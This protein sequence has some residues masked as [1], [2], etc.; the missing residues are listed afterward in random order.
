MSSNNS[1]RL[2]TWRSEQSAANAFIASVNSA[3]VDFSVEK[4]FNSSDDNDQS[5]RSYE[6]DPHQN[7]P[8]GAGNDQHPN[9]S[10]NS[11]SSGSF[12]VAEESDSSDTEINVQTF[13]EIVSSARHAL[14]EKQ[15]LA[16][17]DEIANWAS[18]HR[19]TRD[20][21]NGVLRILNE[22]FPLIP[23]DVRTLLQTE[24]NILIS[25]K[26]GGQYSYFGIL[27]GLVDNKMLCEQNRELIMQINVDGLPLYS[28]RSDSFWPILMTVNKSNP[29]VVALYF[30]KGKPA[31]VSGFMHDFLEEYKKLSSGFI[32]ECIAYTL[33]LNSIVCDAPARAFLKQIIGH[34]GLHGCERCCAKAVHRGRVCFNEF[35]AELRSDEDFDNQTYEGTH[36]TG[37][38]PFATVFNCVTGF[39]LDY[40]H[41]VCLGTLRRMIKFWKSD[42]SSK[43]R[44]SAAHQNGISTALEHL[45]G[46]LPSEFARQPRSLHES[47]RWKATE[48]RQLLLYTGVVVL[49]GILP[50]T[51]YHHFMCLCVSMSILL[52]DDDEFRAQYIEYARRLL[53]SFVKESKNLY[54]ETFISYNVHS[55][56]HLAD[57][58]INFNTSLNEQSAFPYE[59]FLGRLKRLVRNGNNP[60]AQVGKRLS[61]NRCL[62]GK[63]GFVRKLAA[64]MRDGVVRLKCG[65]VGI[66]LETQVNGIEVKVLPRH[67]L[68]SLFEVPC[69]SLILGISKIRN[70]GLSNAPVNI[71]QE[72]DIDS[73]MVCLPLNANEWALLPMHHLN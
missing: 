11:C 39:S 12:S 17:R 21:A 26:F 60:I 18:V 29:V 7:V 72:T 69:D 62:V 44:L 34:N 64:G 31:D 40:M 54:G 58:C 56:I 28:S 8:V 48:W 38:S 14:T 19:P 73:K 51:Y 22:M 53:I 10:V 41:L 33:K 71:I 47:D 15:Q 55:L 57:D 5:L 37:V 63:K 49:S 20:Q 67:R 2:K 23:K 45:H 36:Q 52:D 61:E 3:E 59:N 42:K 6:H 50:M 1:K 30:G 35:N 68:S 13:G 66:I 24:Q 25:N 32:H 46:H 16:V 9:I 43:F 4:F 65:K 27:K 70:S